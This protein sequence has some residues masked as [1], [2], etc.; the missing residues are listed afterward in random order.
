M[1]KAIFIEAGHG[2]KDGMV[3]VGAVGN[4]TTERA[5][6]KQIA[7]ELVERIKLDKRFAGVSVYSVGISEDYDLVEKVQKIN[8]LCKLRGYNKLNSLLISI[9][10]NSGGGTGVESWYYVADNDS[11]KFGAIVGDEL[12]K[13]TGL[14]YR[15]DKPDSENR[16]GRLAIV[17]DTKPLAVLV[18]CGFIDSPDVNVLKDENKDDSFALGIYKGICR[19]LGYEDSDSLYPDVKKNDWFYSVV[20]WGVKNKLVNGYGDGLFRPN[21]QVT[22]AELLTILKRFEEFTLR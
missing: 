8:T 5:E 4:G 1:V 12:S 17:R 15:G 11:K 21:N 2:K 18:E 9:H 6:V 22:R 19:H 20:E 7:S 10:I 13:A 14:V 16:H 3:D